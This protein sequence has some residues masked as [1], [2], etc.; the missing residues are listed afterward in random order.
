MNRLARILAVVPLAV[1]LVSGCA[2][3]P[4]FPPIQVPFA[5]V[6]EGFSV[7]GA[8]GY[9]QPHLTATVVVDAK[10]PTSYSNDWLSV[11]GTLQEGVLHTEVEARISL[12]K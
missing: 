10:V 8:V 4:S 1:A 3:A 12:Q 2:T 5:H 6:G 7:A 9:S 11:S